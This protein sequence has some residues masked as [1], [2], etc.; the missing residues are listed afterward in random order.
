MD[1]IEDGVH[2]SKKEEEYCWPKEP[3]LID[4]IESFRDMKL[5]FMTHLGLWNQAGMMESWALSDEKHRHRWSQLRADWDDI[6]TIKHQYW[7]LNK[8]FIPTRFDPERW[9]KFMARNG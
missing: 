8:S 7:N 2:K 3:I 9:A 1:V 4:K 5:G 6:E